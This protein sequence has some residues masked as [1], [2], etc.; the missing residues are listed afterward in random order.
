MKCQKNVLYFTHTTKP[1]LKFTGKE[2]YKFTSSGYF[3][4]GSG[5]L[6]TSKHQMTM[7]RVIYLK[8]NCSP[9]ENMYFLISFK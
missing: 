2:K 4:S 3:F 9:S 6:F 5:D 1:M 8:G 7:F